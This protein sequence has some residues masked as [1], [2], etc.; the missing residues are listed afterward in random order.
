MEFPATVGKVAA[1][2]LKYSCAVIDGAG[3]SNRMLHW[4]RQTG[5]KA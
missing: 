5:E 3:L 2:A 1:G 4:Q